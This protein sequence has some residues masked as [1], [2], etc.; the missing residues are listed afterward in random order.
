MKLKE[1]TIW[2]WGGGSS[3]QGEN[4]ASTL[5]WWCKETNNHYSLKR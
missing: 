1:H 5:H 3:C 2:N 4:H